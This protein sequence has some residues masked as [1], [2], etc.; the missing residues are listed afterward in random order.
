MNYNRRKA[1]ALQYNDTGKNAP[2]VSASWEGM[3]ADTMI[4]KAQEHNIPILEDASLVELLTELDINQ[5]IPEELYKV[6]AEVFA[7]I[8]KTDQALAKI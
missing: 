5:Q 7:Y 2:K 8:H 3:I 4:E 1:V 6:V